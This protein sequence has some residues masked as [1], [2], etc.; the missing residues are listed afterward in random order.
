MTGGSGEDVAAALVRG[1]VARGES[2]ATAESLTGGL[3]CGALTGVPGASATVRGAVVAYAV[4]VKERVLGVAREVLDAHGAV[5]R[6]C[7]EAMAVGGAGVLGADWC[8]STT[9]V[10][11]PDPSEGKPVGTVHLAVAR[12]E[13]VQAHQMLTLHGDRDQIRKD[14][15]K[16]ALELLRDCLGQGVSGEGG[17]VET[18]GA[19]PAPPRPTRSARVGGAARR[20]TETARDEEG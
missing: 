5:S 19:V 6:E 2:V 3:L 16:A 15:V 8:V 10:A 9:G 20:T 17:T 18:S 7:A 14:T 13:H 12:R 1:L 4:P 11:G